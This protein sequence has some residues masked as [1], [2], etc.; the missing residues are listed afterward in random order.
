MSLRERILTKI[1]TGLVPVEV[2]LVDESALHAGHAASRP[3]GETHFRLRVIGDCFRGLSRVEQHRL[4]YTL[5]A[6]EL[7][8]GVH[9]LALETGI[10][11]GRF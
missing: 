1:E 7:A 4:V 6:E 9:A 5:L 8:A 11:V 3:E 2:S 10:E